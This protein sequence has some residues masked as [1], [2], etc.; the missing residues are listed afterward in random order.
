ME[1]IDKEVHFDEWC[2]KCINWTKREY[3]EPCDDC[4]NYP[5]NQNSTKP[6]NFREKNS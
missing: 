5:C 1:V 3:E 4:L 6:L 2:P